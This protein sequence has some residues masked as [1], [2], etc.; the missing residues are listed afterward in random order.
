MNLLG[1][2]TKLWVRWYLEEPG[3]LKDRSLHHWKAYPMCVTTHQGYVWYPLYNLQSLQRAKQFS[4]I[5]ISYITLERNFIN[6]VTFRSFFNF[7]SY[8]Y[9]KSYGCFSFF[10]YRMF[11]FKGELCKSYHKGILDTS[12]ITIPRFSFYILAHRC[13]SKTYSNNNDSHFYISSTETWENQLNGRKFLGALG[14]FS[15][16]SGIKAHA[17]TSQQ[18]G[19]KDWGRD[20]KKPQF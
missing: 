6:L 20:S 19:R 7:V 3:W 11:Q 8:V 9:F 2:F 12:Y 14:F 10:H 1:L 18:T 15:A 5:V 4:T 17:F 13:F 16:E